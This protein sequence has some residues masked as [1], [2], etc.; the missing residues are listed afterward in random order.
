MI[1]TERKSTLAVKLEM[2]NLAGTA[3]SSG[4]TVTG[5]GTAFDTALEVGDVIGTLSNGF[6]TVTAIAS[7]TSLTVDSAYS[8]AITAG[9]T[10][11]K[12]TFGTDPTIAS[13]DVVEFVDFTFEPERGEITRDVKR[14]T[15][16]E[17][18]PV[19]GA[20]TVSGNVQI[21]L[22]GSGTA[23]VAPES[24]PL[25]LC[26]F[27]ERLTTTAS[28]VDGTATTTVIPVTAGD[29]AKFKAGMHIMVD[30]GGGVYEVARIT[31]VSTDD[32]TVSPAFSAAPADTTVISAG[33]HY[34]TSLR[35]ATL[36]LRNIRGI[37]VHRYLFLLIQMKQ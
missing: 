11:K 2:T 35:E 23:G 29:G 21:E 19:L 24:D 22:H 1:A 6:R 17:I 14:R 7:A 27:G 4:T 33:I 36:P 32:L 28:A 25:W 10:L 30:V 12:Q 20:E 15:F 34:S 37:N 31:S 3:A 8:I 9:T 5:T 16:D 13:S 26:A 18:E